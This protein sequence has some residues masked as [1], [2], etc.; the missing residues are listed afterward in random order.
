[1]WK[2]LVALVVLGLG[3]SGNAGGGGPTAVLKLQAC[4]VVGESVTL[5]ASDSKA[6]GG[7]IVRYVFTIGHSTP[8]LVTDKSKLEYVFKEPALVEGKIV[9][10]EILLTVVDEKGRESYTSNKIFVVFSED[11]CPEPIVEERDVAIAEV[12]EL[13]EWAEPPPD[14]ELS[15]DQEVLPDVS[16][17]SWLECPLD[18]ARTYHLAVFCLGQMAIEMD[19]ELE[20]SD[21]EVWSTVIGDEVVLVMEVDESG[22]AHLSSGYDGLVKWI[23]DC[24]GII[25]SPESF[26]LDCTSGCTVVFEER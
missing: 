14:V 7:E 26:D 18:L 13:T 22:A 17:E 19:V 3:C 16:P 9:P 15:P 23:E 10:Y 2:S 11:Q 24:E 6:D 20:T 5:D 12:R 21:C 1:M 8:S 25:D 4:A